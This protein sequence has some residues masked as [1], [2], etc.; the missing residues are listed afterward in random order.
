MRFAGPAAVLAIATVAMPFIFAII[1]ASETAGQDLR[2]LWVALAA[3]CGATAG[4]AMS[5]GWRAHL[6]VGLVVFSVFIGALLCGALAASLLGVSV[7][8]GMFL[9]VGGFAS[10]FGAGAFLYIRAHHVQ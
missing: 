1:R 3:S 6:N 9:V 7:G 8:P 10:C 4:W 2:Y 5:R